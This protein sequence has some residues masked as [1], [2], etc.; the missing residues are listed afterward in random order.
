[1]SAVIEEEAVLFADLFAE[2]VYKHEADDKTNTWLTW[3]SDGD[4]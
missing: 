4:A 2:I 3:T 1:M